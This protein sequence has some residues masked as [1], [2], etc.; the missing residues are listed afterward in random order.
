MLKN[1]ATNTSDSH[2]K[3]EKNYTQRNLNVPE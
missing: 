1:A 2:L 3:N